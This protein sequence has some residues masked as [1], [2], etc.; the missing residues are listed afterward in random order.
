MTKAVRELFMIIFSKRAIGT[1]RSYINRSENRFTSEEDR[2]LHV[3][4][5]WKENL[6]YEAPPISNG[7]I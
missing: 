2:A 5:N 6:Y 3:R 4:R 1:T 7:Y